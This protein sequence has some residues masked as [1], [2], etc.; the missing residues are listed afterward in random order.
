[1][2]KVNLPAKF[3][4][5]HEHWRPKVAGRLN[6]Q[7]VRLVKI[8][9]EFPW[10]SHAGADEMFLCWRGRFR[11]DFR[12]RSVELEPGEFIV[13]PMGVEHRP[14]AEAECEI[15]LIEP[16]GT[17]NTGELRDEAFTAPLDVEV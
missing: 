9:G 14:V 2:D 11:M 13:V 1:M 7:E 5:F 17:V 4:A 8:L 15:V 12:D 10:H 3:A 6:G 16:A